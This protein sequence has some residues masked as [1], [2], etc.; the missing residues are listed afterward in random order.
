MSQEKTSF[1]KFTIRELNRSD[2]LNAEYNPRKIKPANRERLKKRIE[3]VGLLT[4]IVWNERT[5]NIVSGHQRVSIL[6]SLNR[7][8]KYPI[9][10]AVVDLDEAVEKEQ[11][12]FFNN[13]SSQGEWDFE[14][15]ADIWNDTDVNMFSAGF[16]EMDVKMLFGATPE[17]IFEEKIETSVTAPVMQETTEEPRPDGYE[18]QEPEEENTAWRE[19]GDK[20]RE[21]MEHRKRRAAVSG[22]R[23]D[24]DFYF[25]AV[26]KT[27]AERDMFLSDYGIEEAQFIR[28]DLLQTA[29][30]ERS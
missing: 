19:Q 30:K 22:V 5:G 7:S 9:T 20:V 16:S 8:K 15:L 6:D 21:G 3:Q 26:F 13:Q 29:I 12:I 27:K 25:V 18:E 10:V 17:D 1:E 14:K 4:P 23:E 11:V 28:G 24:S 2:L